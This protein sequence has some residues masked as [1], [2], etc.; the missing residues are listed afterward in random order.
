M[1][2]KHASERV[3]VGSGGHSG[4]IGMRTQSGKASP[5]AVRTQPSKE[6]TNSFNYRTPL[7]DLTNT[8]P[9]YPGGPAHEFW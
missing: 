8:Q 1:E 4:P 3:S 6:S 2:E 5:I 9:S 7:D